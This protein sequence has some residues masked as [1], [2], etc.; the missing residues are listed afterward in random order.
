MAK[1]SIFSKNYEKAVKKRRMKLLVI[2]VAVV[3][4]IGLVVY[5]TIFKNKKLN[6]V[7]KI[8]KKTETQN[9]NNKT[10]IN[11][12]EKS[13]DNS[14]KAQVKEEKIKYI[15]VNLNENLNVKISYEENGNRKIYKDVINE[16][17]NSKI[18]CD[19]NPSKTSLLVY[20][21]KTQKIFYVNDEGKELDI[22]KEQYVSKNGT[23]FSRENKIKNDENYLWCSSPRFVDEENIVFISRLPWLKSNGNKFIWYGKVGENKYRYIKNKQGS[24]IQFENIN[25][26][27]LAV[28]IDD[29]VYYITA[30]GKIIE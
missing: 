17:D 4:V 29:K 19:L 27:G 14:S 8:N 15:T 3:F 10:S 24:D 11:N 2:I 13:K 26:K 9:T 20:D 7:N 28:K 30:D 25:E 5:I 22:S 18:Y 21:E 1:P 6:I 12:E 23:V 16:K